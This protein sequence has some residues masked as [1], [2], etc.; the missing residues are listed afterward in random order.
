[1]PFEIC[2]PTNDS[3]EGR[4]TTTPSNSASSTTLILELA[5]TS[6]T[7]AIFAYHPRAMRNWISA[8]LLIATALVAQQTHNQYEPPNGPGA[9]QKAV[10]TVCG[11]LGCGVAQIQI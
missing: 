7:I 4:S 9:G 6:A 3:L 2:M 1:M 5:T 10:H 11:R 8:I